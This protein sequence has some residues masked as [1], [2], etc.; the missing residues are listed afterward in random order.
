M[1]QVSE[2]L[3]KVVDVHI[4]AYIYVSG[5]VACAVVACG[6]L[7]CGLVAY[8]IA[9]GFRLVACRNGRL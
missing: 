7:A 2:Q 4:Y 1:L 9:Y 8:G 5:L 3:P 6:Q